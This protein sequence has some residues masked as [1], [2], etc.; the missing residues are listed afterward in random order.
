MRNP[1][2]VADYRQVARENTAFARLAAACLPGLASAAAMVIVGPG[3]FP[4]ADASA[5]I[6]ASAA[7]GHAARVGVALAGAMALLAY[8]VGVRGP[9]RGLVDLHPV[10][11]G[12]YLHA[13]R[14]RV[15]V[16]GVPWLAGALPL[17][18]PLGRDI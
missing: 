1:Y 2:L 10:H 3:A 18:F 6:F 7:A 4:W 16:A 8:D 11:A 9:D 5:S 13:R 14:R 12:P 15:A 17:L